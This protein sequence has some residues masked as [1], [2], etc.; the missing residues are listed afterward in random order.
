VGP[1]RS[2]KREE[3]GENPPDLEESPYGGGASLAV[4]SKITAPR[5]GGKH[6]KCFV[7]GG[8][9][10]GAC[11]G[12]WGQVCPHPQINVGNKLYKR[13]KKT[14][15]CGVKRGAKKGPK[16]LSRNAKRRSCDSAKLGGGNRK[17]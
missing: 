7:R 17:V 8:N 11:G 6:R 3:R 9:F 13:K 5:P 10:E 12:W 4:L 2:I 14:I 15:R 16:L 1:E